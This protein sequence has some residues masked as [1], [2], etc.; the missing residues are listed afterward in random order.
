MTQDELIEKMLGPFC[1]VLS[2]GNAQCADDMPN[3][4]IYRAA[5]TAAYTALRE[6]M[7][8]VAWLCAGPEGDKELEHHHP[9]SPP[10]TPIDEADGWSAV[11]LYTLPEAP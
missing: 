7:E 11:P 2:G 10:L 9:V 3:P 8:P 1:D 6:A 4:A 5:M